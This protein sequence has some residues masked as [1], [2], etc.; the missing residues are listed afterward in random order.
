MIAAIPPAAPPECAEGDAAGAGPGAPGGGAIVAHTQPTLFAI[1]T[2]AS[3]AS[4][5]SW[6]MLAHCGPE[7]RGAL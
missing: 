2:T 5:M 7:S 4:P 6:Q 3:S 1:T